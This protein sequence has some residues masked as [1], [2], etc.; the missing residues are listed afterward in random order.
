MM[1]SWLPS[2]IP[3]GLA[4][5][6]G[7]HYA[8]SAGR[9][10][11]ATR[12][13]TKALGLQPRRDPRHPAFTAQ[14]PRARPAQAP[15][16]PRR[17]AALYEPPFSD[18]L[19]MGLSVAALLLRYDTAQYQPLPT[20]G[21]CQARRDFVACSARTS[22]GARVIGRN[23]TT[24]RTL[25]TALTHRQRAAARA[26][27]GELHRINHGH[28]AALSTSSHADAPAPS[29]CMVSSVRSC[30]SSAACLTPACRGSHI[31]MNT[32]SQQAHP[33][34]CSKLGQAQWRDFRREGILMRPYWKLGSALF[35]YC[36]E[37]NPRIFAPIDPPHLRR[38]GGDTSARL[39]AEEPAPWKPNQGNPP[40]AG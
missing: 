38:R 24:A 32:P 39:T 40:M 37:K 16:S 29:R 19:L 5:A 28:L 20:S 33:L 22:A 4:E 12:V 23:L 10:A 31:M 6:T 36:G 17:S 13:R 7:L 2:R 34:R 1:P 11:I 8:K 21:L 9:Q 30:S 26:P 18:G 14:D 27:S 35:H 3:S 25:Q 15:K